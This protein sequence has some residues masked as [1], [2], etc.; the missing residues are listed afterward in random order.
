MSFHSAIAQSEIIA[1]RNKVDR[2][3]AYLP[4][5]EA[6]ALT[7]LLTNLGISTNKVAAIIH[8]EGRDQEDPVVVEYFDISVSAI[9]RW[10]DSNPTIV[11]GL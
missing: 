10:R 8:E 9:K 3:L 6:E 4:D 1:A 11:D 2:L 7:E 5:S